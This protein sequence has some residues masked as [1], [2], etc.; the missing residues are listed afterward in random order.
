[1]TRHPYPAELYE[2]VH[3]GTAGDVAFYQ[4]ACVD[5]NGVLELG[6][7]YG[8][9][10]SALTGRC[11]PLTGLDIDPELLARASLRLGKVDGLRLVQ[12][13][14]RGF[15]RADTFAPAAGFDRILIPY[16]GVYCLP[17]EAACVACFQSCAAQLAAGGCL[18][19]DAYAADAFHRDENPGDHA[20]ERLDPIVSVEIEGRSYDVFERSRW[21]RHLQQLDVTYEYIPRGGGEA[22]QGRLLHHYLLRSQIAPLLERAGLRLHSLHGDWRGH[23]SSSESDMWVA[24]ARHGEDEADSPS[25]PSSS[26]AC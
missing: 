4:R 14:M 9:V 16:S 12:A 21:D 6:C 2:L 23:P 20:D 22:L 3:R 10:L 19:F 25:S 11:A 7:G 13:D 17:D 24:T 8:R 15:D 1:M 5:A 18:I 26:P